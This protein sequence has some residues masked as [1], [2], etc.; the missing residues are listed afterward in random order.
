MIANVLIN[1][2]MRVLVRFNKNLYKDE[3]YLTHTLP[4]SKKTIYLSKF[5]SSI[6]TMITSV[7]VIAT[8][9]FIAYYSKENITSLK[10]ILLPIADLYN[11]SI[12]GL[13][14]IMTL[15]IG[16]E[17]LTFLQCG[18]TGLILGHRKNSNKML[19]SIIYG[20]VT[21]FI[22]QTIILIVIFISGLIDNDIMTLFTSSTITNIQ[23]FKE[24]IYIAIVSYTS[25]I[26]GNYF[27]NTKLFEK[28]VNVD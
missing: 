28:G 11:S 22:T 3:S 23:L 25:C 16:L 1:N 15:L 8:T 9:L 13:I 12:I 20:I 7:L 21:Y 27:I 6:I 5:L 26:I 14:S 24:V 17:L 2:F 18:Y 10:N 4:V 19:Y